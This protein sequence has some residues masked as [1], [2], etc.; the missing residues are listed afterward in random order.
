VVRRGAQMNSRMALAALSFLLLAVTGCGAASTGSSSPA[1]S[2]PKPIPTSTVTATC[3]LSSSKGKTAGERLADRWWMVVASKG[4]A[5]HLRLVKDFFDASTGLSRQARDDDA[6]IELSVA[7]SQLTLDAAVLR[8]SVAIYGT[9]KHGD[10]I[11]VADSGNALMSQ[12]SIPDARFRTR[13]L[14]MRASCKAVIQHSTPAS[15]ALR[16]LAEDGV[17]ENLTV[18]S[19]SHPRDLLFKDQL[20][21]PKRLRSPIGT[22]V[23]VL[24]SLVEIYSTGRKTTIDS[25]AYQAAG[26]K[27]VRSCEGRSR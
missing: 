20:R 8:A 26:A 6:C 2:D 12:M 23:T 15:D 11:R 4:D 9:A 14:S 22:M 16:K 27:V 13:L 10:Y 5:D 19:F 21:A 3:S 1:S 25:W 17:S 24:D 18:E 7:S